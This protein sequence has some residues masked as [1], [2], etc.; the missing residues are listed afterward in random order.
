[1]KNIGDMS[2]REF[3]GLVCEALREGGIPVTRTGS[4]PFR[5]NL[6]HVAIWSGVSSSVWIDVIPVRSA[7]RHAISAASSNS[8]SLGDGIFA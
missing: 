6:A 2:V 1:M 7:T 3:A 4:F 8:F 5:R